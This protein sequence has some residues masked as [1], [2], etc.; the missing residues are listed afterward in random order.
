[1]CV[2]W[3]VEQESAINKKNSNVLVAASAG[4]G[5]TSV[6]ITRVIKKVLEEQIDIDKILVVTFTNAAALELKQRLEKELNNKLKEKGA[7]RSFIKRQIRLLNRSNI[8]TIHS[9]CLKI[10]RF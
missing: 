9:F 6:L 1:M 2:M 3:T 4:S 8:S 5:K 10:I 7:E